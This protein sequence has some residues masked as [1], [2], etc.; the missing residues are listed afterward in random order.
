MALLPRVR[1]GWRW[2]ALAALVLCLLVPRHRTEELGLGAEL[3][4]A[5]WPGQG[6]GGSGPGGRGCLGP[7]P[8][9]RGGTRSGERG[10][11]G[12][13]STPGRGVRGAGVP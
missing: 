2:G 13:G 11:G 9:V 5:G 6:C 7:G 4:P 8:G 1:W 3:A 12:Q 10:A